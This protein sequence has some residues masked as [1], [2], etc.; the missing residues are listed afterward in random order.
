MAHSRKCF[1]YV[2]VQCWEAF[3]LVILQGPRLCP[4]W[5]CTPSRGPGVLYKQP[6]HRKAAVKEGHLLL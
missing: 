5:D 2:I 3:V 4:S 6:V 1:V